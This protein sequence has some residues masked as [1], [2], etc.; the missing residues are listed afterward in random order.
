MNDPIPVEP[1]DSHTTRPHDG[2]QF[3][4]ARGEP[5]PEGRWGLGVTDPSSGS[6][7]WLARGEA[8][9]EHGPHIEGSGPGFDLRTG[10]FHVPGL[11]IDVPPIQV[12]ASTFS[13]AVDA[14][15]HDRQYNVGAQFA[16]AEG[17]IS[18]GYRDG[19]PR[20]DDD[21]WVR[22]G[23]SA[24]GEGFAI[25]VNDGSDLDHDRVPEFGLGIDVGVFSADIRIESTAPAALERAIE[26]LYIPN[27]ADNAQGI[28][29]PANMPDN[30]GAPTAA[31]MMPDIVPL[32][33]EPAPAG[34]GSASNIQ[35]PAPIAKGE[36]GADQSGSE[37][38]ADTAGKV[39]VDTLPDDKADSASKPGSGH[40]I[41][42][43]LADG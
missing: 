5:I 30:S 34:T 39:E 3:Q 6:S 26:N 38:H 10:P 40:D 2:A 37:F 11:E 32:A 43:G 41:D 23:G 15:A 35:D 21:V 17:G 33:T 14:T 29:A 1:T 9:N 8:D 27:F 20:S 25:R 16:A 13:A 22:V 12:K 19:N 18:A 24:G 36:L 7:I 42:D 4:P 31:A 28:Q